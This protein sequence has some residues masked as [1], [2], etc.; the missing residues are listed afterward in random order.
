MTDQTNSDSHSDLEGPQQNDMGGPPPLLAHGEDLSSMLDVLKESWTGET[1]SPETAMAQVLQM[2]SRLNEM[3]KLVQ[4]NME[5]A[6]SRQKKSY[7]KGARPRTLKVGDEVLVLLPNP[8][9][10]LKLEWF[11]PYNITRQVTP[12]DYEIEMTDR[13]KEKRVY[14]INLMKKIN[15]TIHHLQC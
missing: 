12:V 10:A 15:G 14:H 3:T 8:H 9:D 11:G 5:R 4:K 6:Q 1:S 7:D 13:R 2:R